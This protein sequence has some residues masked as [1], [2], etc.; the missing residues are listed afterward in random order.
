VLAAG[1]WLGSGPAWAEERGGNGAAPAELVRLTL[2]P[3]EVVL[4]GRGARQQFLVTGHYADGS[5]RDLTGATVFHTDR[6]DRLRLE[7]GVAYALGDG[8]AVVTARAGGREAGVRVVARDSGRVPPV[9]FRTDV[10]AVLS[11][12]GCNAGTCHGNFNGKNGFRLSLRGENP[13][14]DLDSLARDS[15]GRRASPFDPAA[16]LLLQKPTG[17][18]PHEGGVRFRRDSEEYDALRRWVAGGL[19]PDSED[20]PRLSRLEVLPRERVLLHGAKRQQLVARASFSDGT[21]RDVSHLAV[22]EPSVP[23]VTVTPGGLV[24]AD[25][26]GEVTVVVRYLDRRVPCRLAFV[27]ER[28]GFRWQDVAAVNYIDR[29][30][31][32][33]LRS[34]RTQPSELADDATF[35]RRAY[36]DVC[37]VLPTADEARAFLADRDPA[38]RAR[39]VDRLLER[40]E[41]ADYW[42]LKWADLLRNEEKAVDAKGVRHFQQW[43]RQGVGD[44]KPLDRFARELLTARGSTYERPEANYYRTNLEPQKA[45]ETTAQLFLGVRLACARCH[46]HP[47]DRW[48]QDDY[49]GLSAFFARVRTRMVENQRRDRFDK[50]ELNGE[51]LVWLDRAG[52]VSHPRTGGPMP[53]RLPGGEV[54]PLADGADR[55]AALADWVTARDNPFFARVTANRIWYHLMG[56]G[57]VEPVDDFRESNPPSN[58]PLLDA[59]AADLA[60]HGFSQ[61]HLIR[62]IMASRTYQLS[63]RPTPSNED[64]E[65]NFSHVQPRLLAAEPLL[66]ALSQVTGV[67]EEFKGFPRG[68]RAVQL[69]GVGNAPGFLKMFGKPDRLL[70]C[71]CER[72]SDTTLGQAFQLI[73]GESITYKVQHTPVIDRLLGRKASDE[74]VVTEFYLAALA[75]YPKPRELELA[76]P[77]LGRAA[78]RRRAVEDLLWAVVNTKEFLLRR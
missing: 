73:S 5:V 63:S 9:R 21:V 74:E 16:S 37:G 40:P 19:R 69:P 25:Q 15:H 52:E 66:D 68:T 20:A 51:M 43:L 8:E 28:P 27:P 30:V 35:L 46:N 32:A 53:P 17:Q 3:A 29:H 7:S 70:A 2:E 64:D 55:L 47:F 41:Y 38:K 14:F 13:A 65:T 11:K 1:C 26:D 78:D 59:L 77:R 45:A 33:K 62:V 67:P 12:G 18:V 31:F 57:I 10:M 56:R 22:Y 61:K 6:P 36:L 50:H 23:S 76:A 49:Y 75:R 4:A 24:T 39:L 34:L 54:P 72:R 44:D 71:E 48:T 60:G 58:G 42:G